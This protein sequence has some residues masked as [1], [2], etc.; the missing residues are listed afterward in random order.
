[1]L[2]RLVTSNFEGTST[3]DLTPRVIDGSKTA[4]QSKPPKISFIIFEMYF[5]VRFTRKCQRPMTSGHTNAPSP[6]AYRS[7]SRQ[8]RMFTSSRRKRSSHM[9]RLSYGSRTTPKHWCVRIVEMH[10]PT[11]DCQL[12]PL[13]YDEFLL[14]ISDVTGELMRLAITSIACGERERASEIC[15]FVRKC[16]AGVSAFLSIH[17]TDECRL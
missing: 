4:R 17:T 12:F 15:G 3:T 7:I 9:K 8:S 1:M 11:H 2:H 13:P 10:R 14:G 6:Q 16:S 5:Y